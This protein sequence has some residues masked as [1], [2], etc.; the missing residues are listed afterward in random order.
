MRKR[1]LRPRTVVVTLSILISLIGGY[2]WLVRAAFTSAI[3]VNVV[4]PPTSTGGS[5]VGGTGVQQVF[6]TGGPPSTAPFAGLDPGNPNPALRCPAGST[7]TFLSSPGIMGPIGPNDFVYALQVSYDPGSTVRLDFVSNGTCAGRKITSVGY[8]VVPALEN[9][10]V[11]GGQFTPTQVILL[12]T[13]VDFVFDDIAGGVNHTVPPGRDTAV[14]FFTSPDP[15]SLQP[16]SIQS[17]GVASNGTPPG[18]PPGVTTPPIYGPCPASLTIDKKIGC[19]P[20]GPFT[21]G[22]LTALAGSQVYYQ[23]TVKNTGKVPLTNL[24]VSDPQLGGDLT[25]QFNFPDVEVASGTLMPG[26]APMGTPPPPG[27]SDDPTMR[28]IVVPF[29]APSGP[30]LPGTPVTVVNTATAKGDYLIPKQ[31]GTLNPGSVPSGPV[32][33]VAVGPVTDSVT[34]NVVAPAILCDK[35]VNG[36][37]LLTLPQNTA[38]PLVLN[39]TLKATNTGTTDLAVV[40]DDPKIKA[41]KTAPPAGVTINMAI[42]GGAG[43]AAGSLAGGTNLQATFPVVPPSGM[44]QVNIAVTLANKAAFSALTDPGNPVTAS[45]IMTAVGT[46][47]NFTGCPP[48]ANATTVD[49]FS[50]AAVV[51]Q[52]CSI[53]LTKA[54]ACDTGT[55]INPPPPAGSFGSSVT[56]LVNAGVVFRYVVTNTGTDTLNNVTITDNKITSPSFNV[57]TLTAGQSA[58]IFVASTAPGTAGSVINT[59]NVTA[60]SQFAGCN[61]SAGPATAT[62][63]TVAPNIA[64]SKQVN[65]G[66]SFTIPVDAVY[67]VALNYTL[68]AT[69]TGTTSLSIVIDDP[70]LKALKTAPPAGVTINMA[71]QG[72]AGFAA[73]TLAGGTNLQAT[74]ATVPPAGMAQV[75]VTLTLASAAA[76]AAIADSGNALQST[77]TMTA[78]GTVTSFTGCTTNATTVNCSSSAVVN[79]TPPEINQSCVIRECVGAACRGN[80]PGALPDPNAI[81]S[82]DKEGSVLFYNFYS[83]NIANPAA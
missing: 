31:D 27:S 74:F 21:D 29:T 35:K 16:A 17:S 6:R 13:G 60:N 9:Q 20:N 54:V 47:T 76:F 40:I 83:S 52:D 67:P 57:G 12:S 14:L 79:L 82:D 81:V 38:F 61:V 58:T 44:A 45:N 26:L 28:M 34:L 75:N 72:G 49:C 71:I 62:V 70:K 19:S 42:Q 43:F 80:D 22:P 59:A 53:S 23:I 48:N 32:Q 30:P 78:V 66:S 8:C 73:G 33:S 36:V 2:A 15:P 4:Y 24:M 63:N 55:G 5:T 18:S 10:N 77:N 68:K 41:L 64:C 46:V 7:L 50:D 3:T 25:S 69:N 11:A 1:I 56:A 65:G 51:F 37:S 39:Y